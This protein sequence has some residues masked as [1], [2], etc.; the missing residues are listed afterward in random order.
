M[1]MKGQLFSIEMAL[2]VTAVFIVLLAL[3]SFSHSVDTPNYDL[4]SSAV[5]AH[6]MGE[7][8]T[9][10]PPDDFSTACTTHA[11]T[12]SYYDYDDTPGLEVCLK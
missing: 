10:E 9:S 11:V 3:F 8:D 2:I 4:F 6:D 12:F 5:V 1:Q 7:A